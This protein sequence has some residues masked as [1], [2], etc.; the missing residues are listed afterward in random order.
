VFH[1][2]FPSENSGTTCHVSIFTQT[3]DFVSRGAPRVVSGVSN[4]AP[5]KPGS[6]KNFGAAM[7]A[8]RCG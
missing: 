7:A 1:E 3:G 6:G 4:L 5:G 8:R 2:N